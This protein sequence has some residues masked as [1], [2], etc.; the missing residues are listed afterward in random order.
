MRSSEHII[1]LV[2]L[3]ATFALIQSVLC[4][5]TVWREPFDDANVFVHA[6]ALRFDD[7]GA[8]TLQ[9]IETP[10]TCLQTCAASNACQLWSYNP[11]QQT[12]THYP[13]RFPPTIEANVDELFTVPSGIKERPALPTFGPVNK[14]PKY[15]QL[16]HTALPPQND[17]NIATLNHVNGLD[18][19]RQSCVESID[20][21]KQ[22]CI[23][24]EYDFDKRRC[25][26][27]RSIHG[28]LQELSSSSNIDTYLVIN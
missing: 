23:S 28:D 27:A 2:I 7:P 17:G 4:R 6:T 13:R 1:V 5:P 8:L 11:I 9:N 26:L 18:A 24:F 22:R 14:S 20:T 3:I 15:F 19:C 12:C 10:S 16:A 21:F 25:T